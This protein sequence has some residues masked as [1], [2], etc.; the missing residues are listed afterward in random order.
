[1]ID[2]AEHGVTLGGADSKELTRSTPATAI[3]DMQ[4]IRVKLLA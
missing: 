2:S 4:T 3:A 1:M